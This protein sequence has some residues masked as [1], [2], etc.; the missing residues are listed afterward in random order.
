MRRIRRGQWLGILASSGTLV[1]AAAC[2]D[3]F[4]STEFETLCTFDS[5][6]CD[7]GRDGSSEGGARA[8]VGTDGAPEAPPPIDFCESSPSEARIFAQRACGWTGACLGVRQRALHAKEFTYAE[9]FRRA[10]AA[11]DCSFNPSLRPRGENARLWSCLTSVT[12][13]ASVEQCVFGNVAP[14]CNQQGPFTACN[15]KENGSVVI[16]CGSTTRALGMEACALEGRVCTRVDDS[17]AL[18]TGALAAACKTATPRCAGTS[19][20]TCKKAGGIDWDEGFDCATV[21]DGRC[22]LDDAGP[23]CAPQVDASACDV[24]TSSAPTCA[25]GGIVERCVQGNSTRIACAAL[26]QGCDATKAVVADPLSACV[27]VGT[28]PCTENEDQCA[29][30][31]LS[32]CAG[33]TKYILDCKAMGLGACSKPTD[34]HAACGAPPEP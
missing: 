21:G 1:G 5:D 9:C 14:S 12:S 19:L 25:D 27:E 8:D 4:H 17:T 2:V 15:A 7:G 26:E 31:L 22:V 13:C 10:L 32:S 3:L 28:S 18:C 34:R 11:Y 33:G 24:A 29:G 30:G 23:A 6:A 20:V 16:E